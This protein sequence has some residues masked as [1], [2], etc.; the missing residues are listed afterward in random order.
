MTEKRFKYIMFDGFEDNGEY[1]NPQEVAKILNE[2]YEENK[3]IKQ[4]IHRMLVQIEVDNI[5]TK[6]TRYWAGIIFTLEEFQKMQQIWKGD[7]E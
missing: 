5:N 3:E 1:L 6:N 4:L 7:F 2:L